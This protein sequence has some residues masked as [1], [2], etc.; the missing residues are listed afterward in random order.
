MESMAIYK[1]SKQIWTKPIPPEDARR[2]PGC[3]IFIFD[4]EAEA[5]AGGVP[6][7]ITINHAVGELCIG[8][9]GGDESEE[10]LLTLVQRI[11]R[12]ESVEREEIVMSEQNGLFLEMEVGVMPPISA[13]GTGGESKYAPLEEALLKVPI[14]RNGNSEWI[15]FKMA[16]AKDVSNA[17][18]WLAKRKKEAYQP[19]GHSLRRRTVK[20]EDG[21]AWLYVQRF[22]VEEEGAS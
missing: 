20:N 17:G 11:R 2:C 1:P 7:A 5:V 10:R 9:A 6:Y 19:Q 22:K 3:G 21:T 8:C 18:T 16:S 13:A 12:G 15:R 4:S 14:G